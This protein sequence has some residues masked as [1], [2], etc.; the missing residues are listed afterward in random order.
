[1]IESHWSNFYNWEGI[2]RPFRVIA[3]ATYFY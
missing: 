3:V 1:M 2:S